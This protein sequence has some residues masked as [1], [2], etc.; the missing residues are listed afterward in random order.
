LIKAVISHFKGS[1]DIELQEIAQDKLKSFLNSKDPNCKIKFLKYNSSE[2]FGTS[3][4][5]RYLRKRQADD[6]SI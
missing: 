1:E 4:F 3:D 2:I 6:I 5:K